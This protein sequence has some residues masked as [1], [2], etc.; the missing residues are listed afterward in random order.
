MQSYHF[1]IG[2]LVMRYKKRNVW[3]ILY[4]KAKNIEFIVEKLM[5]RQTQ[6]ILEQKDKI[7][8]HKILKKVDI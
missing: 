6:N 8:I 3:F 4:V 2:L 7:H 1:S 5:G